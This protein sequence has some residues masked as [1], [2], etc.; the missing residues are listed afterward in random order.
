MGF[1]KKEQGSLD[2]INENLAGLQDGE[3]I[4]AKLDAMPKEE[5]KAFIGQTTLNEMENQKQ[6]AD[7]QDLQEKVAAAKG[8]ALKYKEITKANK[9]VIEYAKYIL[10]GQGVVGV[11]ETTVND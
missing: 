10:E 11:S 6:K 3:A 9:T 4:K 2:A 7:D 1:T 8:A 5:L